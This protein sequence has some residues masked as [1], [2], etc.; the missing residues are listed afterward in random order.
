MSTTTKKTPWLE[1]LIVDQNE[2]TAWEAERNFTWD[3]YE[4]GTWRILVLDSETGFPVREFRSN[5]RWGKLV[6]KQ[7]RNTYDS[8]GNA[9]GV[10]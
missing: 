7:I 1:T 5:M 8:K 4:G 2:L 3:H 10:S 9:L 6:K